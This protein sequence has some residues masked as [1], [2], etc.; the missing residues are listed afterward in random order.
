MKSKLLIT[1]LVCGATLLTIS[2]AQAQ[3]TVPPAASTPAAPD[4]TAAA[5][6]KHGKHDGKGKGHMAEMAKELGLTA[7]Q[8]AKIF[9]ENHEK[10]KAARDDKSGS[11]KE[12][13]AKMKEMRE[14]MD[15]KIRPILTPEQVQKFDAMR[16]KQK[17]EHQGKGKHN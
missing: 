11:P 5:G 14:A 15:A 1:T 7:E 12:Q 17:Q 9:K 16:A 4:A 10:M 8:Q 2:F 3:N 13:H 6:G